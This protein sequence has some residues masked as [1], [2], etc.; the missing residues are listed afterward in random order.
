MENEEIKFSSDNISNYLKSK[1]IKE[2]IKNLN[3]NHYSTIMKKLFICDKLDNSFLNKEDEDMLW[4][5]E[6]ENETSAENKN[7]T[8]DTTNEKTNNNILN[9]NINTPIADSIITIKNPFYLKAQKLKVLEEVSKELSENTFNLRG[10][11][12]K[13]FTHLNKEK[14]I[15]G[16][17]LTLN[18]LRFNVEIIL[19]DIE[20]YYE[21]HINRIK[22]DLMDKLNK[23]SKNSILYIT[24]L[25]AFMQHKK[26]SYDIIFKNRVDTK[27]FLETNSVNDNHNPLI[28]NNTIKNLFDLEK[29]KSQILNRSSIGNI[30]DLTKTNEEEYL[31]II[32][33]STINNCILNI[34]NKIKD[35]NDILIKQVERAIYGMMNA[36]RVN[37]ALTHVDV[38]GMIKNLKTENN[39]TSIELLSLKDSNVLKINHYYRNIALDL[40][41]NMVVFFKNVPVK[42]NKNF[43]IILEN[44][45]ESNIKKLAILS[46]DEVNKLKKFRIDKNKEFD[47]IIDLCR[48]VV[49]RNICKV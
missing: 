20:C 44:P 43:D 10:S 45:L 32:D 47:C 46:E 22:P 16:I 17:E 11:V 35:F 48:P 24:N 18:N 41:I 4:S 37:H 2:N 36:N 1:K 38:C 42:I 13:I 7:I 25:R 30:I 21:I 49:K 27:I 14:E 28:L 5:E 12:N 34:S 31:D 3:V 39:L 9:N 40:K 8:Q 19:K 6:D 33:S 23:F 29:K 26:D 15:E